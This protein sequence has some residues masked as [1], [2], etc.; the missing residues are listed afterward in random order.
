MKKDILIPKVTDVY[1]AVVNEYNEIYNS[2]DW[3]AYIINNK[4]VDL[5]MVLIVTS[6]YNEGKITSTF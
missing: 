5:E 1:V 6:G 2:Q 3:N 4:D